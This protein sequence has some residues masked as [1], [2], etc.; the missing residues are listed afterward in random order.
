M[1]DTMENDPLNGLTNTF[2]KVEENETAA[3][4]VIVHPIAK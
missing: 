2:S 4:Q 3:Y 1:P